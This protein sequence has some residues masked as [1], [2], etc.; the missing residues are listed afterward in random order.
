M[1][2]W[3]RK[4]KG[5][6]GLSAIGGVLGGL[7][8]AARFG[9][10]ALLGAGGWSWEILGQGVL[11][12]GGFAA[13]ATGGVGLLLATAGSRLSLEELSP[14]KAGLVGALLGGLAPVLFVL[15]TFSGGIATPAI[16]SIALRF[17]LLGGILGG[18]LVAVAKRADPALPRGG[19]DPI[20]L[21]RD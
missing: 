4:V 8:G 21:S 16:A 9:V 13:I 14:L 1:S 19:D 6:F 3:V 7:F 17:G 10:L 12:Y 18:G 2:G 15:A 5:V 11:A 20:L